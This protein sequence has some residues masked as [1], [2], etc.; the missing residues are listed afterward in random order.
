M[1]DL[2]NDESAMNQDRQVNETN[3]Q[4]NL[5]L[6]ECDCNRLSKNHTKSRCF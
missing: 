2:D 5:D 3:K 1:N 4:D 6:Q